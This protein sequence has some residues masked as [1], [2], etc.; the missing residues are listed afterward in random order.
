MSPVG[1]DN[2]GGDMSPRTGL[3][4]PPEF[5]MFLAFTELPNEDTQALFESFC[6]SLSI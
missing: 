4:T 5:A 6:V 2:E 1:L 3:K